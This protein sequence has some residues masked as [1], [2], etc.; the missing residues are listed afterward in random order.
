M[1]SRRPS[2]IL[3]PMEVHFTAEQEARLAQLARQ[4]GKRD[5]GELLKD[6]AMRLLEEDARFRAAVLE[7]KP[8]SPSSQFGRSVHAFAERLTG[9]EKVARKRASLFA[10]RSRK[11]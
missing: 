7:G 1:L 4:A 6:A 5:A 9:K 11:G 8:V 3:A 10:L 2:R